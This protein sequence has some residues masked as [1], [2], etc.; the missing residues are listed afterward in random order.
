MAIYA[1]DGTTN[2]YHGT[3]SPENTNV[4]RFLEFNTTEQ[5]GKP[6]IGVLSE[7]EEYVTGVGTRLGIIGHVIGGF[8]GAGGRKRV[9]EFI[10]RL[11]ENWLHG[12]TIV[13]VIGF[14]RGAALALHFCNAL[15]DGI[16]I[17]GER[18]RPDVRFLGLWDTVPSFGLPGVLID[19]F[20][21]INLGWKLNVPSNVKNFYH[22]M[23]LDEDR[24]AFQVHRPKIANPEKTKYE[25]MWFKGTHGDIGGKSS[26]L[27]SISLLWMLEKAR[28]CGLQ[29]IPEGLQ[30][31]QSR[32]DASIKIGENS[33]AGEKEFRKPRI[34]DKFH[35]TA[36]KPLEVNESRTVEVDSKLKFNIFDILIEPDGKYIFEFATDATWI[37]KNIKCSAKGWPD[38]MSSYADG[39]LDQIK[40]TVLT[41]YFFSNFRRVKEANWFELV[42]CLDYDIKTAT[43]IGHGQHSD[44]NTPWSPNS[45]GRLCLFANDAESKYDNNWGTM[46]V[47]VYRIK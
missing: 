47:T 34:N 4:V 38:D 31:V 27:S 25:E 36:A 1:F 19:V 8:T 26:G 32:C 10:E 11:E 24:Q 13:D 23:A 6:V 37:D 42:V 29:I 46:P 28:S 17:G 35:P 12:D 43:P 21:D 41:S 22:A 14:S 3:L 2:E 9:R 44:R 39:V 45:K 7:D 40:F 15:A 5:G 18:I 20:N 33:F 30:R 16:E